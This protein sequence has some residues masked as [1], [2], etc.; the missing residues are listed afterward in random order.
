MPDIGKTFASSLQRRDETVSELPTYDG[1]AGI[2]DR[3]SM[4][5][6]QNSLVSFATEAS[7]V[8]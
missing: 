6:G 5:T 4:N 7:L 1:I 2:T 3:I 8:L